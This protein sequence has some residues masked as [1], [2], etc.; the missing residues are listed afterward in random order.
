MLIH[1]KHTSYRSGQS[2]QLCL[3]YVQQRALQLQPVSTPNN[4]TYREPLDLCNSSTLLVQ[5]SHCDMLG[6]RSGRLLLHPNSV[7]CT[8]LKSSNERSLTRGFGSVILW[9]IHAVSGARE[10]EL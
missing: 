7:F 3:D 5:V 2:K 1:S 6:C 8:S 9:V 4:V 10:S